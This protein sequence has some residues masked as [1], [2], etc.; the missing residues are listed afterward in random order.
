MVGGVNVI[1]R[2]VPDPILNDYVPGA[3]PM[4]AAITSRMSVTL[5]KGHA[6]H[7]GKTDYL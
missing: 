4:V 3:M 2:K 7:H 1:I 6:F 5:T